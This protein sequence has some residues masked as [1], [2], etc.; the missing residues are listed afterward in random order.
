MIK[1][2]GN[3]FTKKA[4]LSL[5]AGAAVVLA[6]GTFSH[7]ALAAD[8]Y[9]ENASSSVVVAPEV[10][11][12]SSKQSSAIVANRISNILTGSGGAPGGGFGATPT[13]SGESKDVFALGK[14][15]GRAAGND[16]RQLGIWATVSNTWIEKDEVGTDADFDG[17]VLNVATGIDYSFNEKLLAG[18]SIGY[19]DQDIDTPFNNGG[20]EG[21]GFTLTPYIGYKITDRLSVD[22][23][24]GYSMIDYDS[25]RQSGAITGNTE[26][27]RIF[28]SANINYGLVQKNGFDLGL[29]GGY[30]YVREDQDAYTESDGTLVEEV[31]VRL[32]QARAGVNLSY[33]HETG[34]GYIKPF[35]GAR[36]EYDNVSNAP[37]V[38]NAA[39]DKGSDDKFGATFKGGVNFGIGD[40]LS[41]NLQGETTEFRDAL[42]VY[43]AS[44][45]VR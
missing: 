18:L 15:D 25:N 45:L 38:I 22:A 3:V 42:E 4:G 7:Q 21:S 12:Q 26:A 43:S 23:M 2:T 35:V 33:T 32:G 19:E 31:N 41:V 39:G 24:L 10:A 13:I 8:T 9:G 14:G 1:I 29:T 5:M 28:G 27:D 20:L 37:G 11:K 16:T 40:N 17:T 6:A 30:L 34:F 44:G 36:A